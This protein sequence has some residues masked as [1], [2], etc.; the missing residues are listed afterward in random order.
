MNEI[1]NVREKVYSNESISK[2]EFHTY[3]IIKHV[4]QTMKFELLSKIKT[5]TC[6]LTKVTLIHRMD[7]QLIMLPLFL[8]IIVRLT[9]GWNE[10]R[11]K[12]MWDW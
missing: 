9:F 2:K 6:F 11:S 5:C 10:V 3:R 1:L 8:K 7:L 12:W 4:N